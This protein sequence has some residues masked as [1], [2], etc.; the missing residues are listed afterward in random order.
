MR[1]SS[2]LISY[3]LLLIKDHRNNNNNKNLNDLE[4]TDRSKRKMDTDLVEQNGRMDVGKNGMIVFIQLY[5]LPDSY[6]IG[7][8]RD[9]I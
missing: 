6:S 2:V 1:S 9:E 7:L 3:F 4:G 8:D 5:R